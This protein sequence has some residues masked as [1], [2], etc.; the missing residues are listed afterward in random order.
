MPK[1]PIRARDEMLL[2]CHRNED[3]RKSVRN[4]LLTRMGQK[5]ARRPKPT[6]H[7]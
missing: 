7:R 6:P 2:F 1:S 5:P 4:H 3:A